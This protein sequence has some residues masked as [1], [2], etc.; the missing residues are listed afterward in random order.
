MGSAAREPRIADK[1]ASEDGPLIR[2][3]DAGFITGS[4]PSINGGQHTY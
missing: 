1:D 2:H 3:W 4:T